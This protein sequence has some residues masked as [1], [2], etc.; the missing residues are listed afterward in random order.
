MR[1]AITLIGILLAV[2]ATTAYAQGLEIDSFNVVKINPDVVEI[3]L[4]GSNDSVLENAYMALSAKSTD[5]TIQSK[6]SLGIQ[7][8]TGQKFH[9]TTQVLR[10]PGLK[11]S[12]TAA[13]LVYLWSPHDKH[14]LKA[15]FDWVHTW[16]ELS[17]DTT[18][19]PSNNL[20]DLYQP[21][22]ISIFYGN[23][24]DDDFA[25]M[26]ALM[27]KWNNKDE[28]DEDGLWQ[29]NGFWVACTMRIQDLGKESLTYFQKWRK[30]NPKS[31]G[32][33][34][35]ESS[36]WMHSAWSIRGRAA[37]HDVDPVAMKV[38]T[39]RS[40]RAEQILK[41]S[42][43][44]STD[45]PLWY[46]AYL[47]LAI[48]TKR[49]D[50]F[51]QALFNESIS[52]HPYYQPLYVLMTQ[53]WLPITGEKANWQKVEEL[54]SQATSLISNKDDAS[55]YARIYSNIGYRQKI[56]F[57]LF[58]ESFASWPTMRDSFESL[59]KQYPSAN[60]LNEFAV[61]ACRA[62]DKDTYLKIRAQIRGHELPRK[63]PSNYSLDM[64]DHMFMQHV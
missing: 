49:E 55:I 15:K 27:H 22:S 42:K 56:E 59:V 58:K 50:Q 16:P 23:L 20:F 9:V 6:P 28:R 64:C 52:K 29:L 13:L 12:Q 25:A 35:A 63:W 18:N 39:E 8:P 44:F 33:A 10:P 30:S 51:I 61:Y 41:D 34:I 62:S 53:H 48:A 38:F 26:D 24:R 7:V 21:D 60:N 40:G 5:G 1:N 47:D 57:N 36:Y 4:V 37:D 2:S 17:A 43:A 45:N 3:E 19:T 46:M 32:A 11:E 14:A 54:V 31:T